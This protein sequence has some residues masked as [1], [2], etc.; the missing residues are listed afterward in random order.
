[1]SI[2][3]LMLSAAFGGLAVGSNF[4][5]SLG[6]SGKPHKTPNGSKASGVAASKRLAT[7][8]NNIRKHC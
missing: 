2:T 5:D 8:R 4:S 6:Y 7:K 3:K 1:M